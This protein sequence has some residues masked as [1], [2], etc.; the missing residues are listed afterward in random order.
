MCIEIN[1]PKTKLMIITTIYR[2]P[3][4]KIDYMDKLEYYLNVLDNENK[5]L[6]VMGDLNCDLSLKL[7]SS[8]T[9]G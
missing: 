1:K 7:S 2:P 5:E 6:I 8:N 4:S 9:F 3:S